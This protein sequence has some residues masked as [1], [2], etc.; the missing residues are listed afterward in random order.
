MRDDLWTWNH[1][2]LAQGNR[3]VIPVELPSFS[4]SHGSSR[5]SRC[6]PHQTEMSGHSMVARDWSR[7]RACYKGMWTLPS[8][9]EIVTSIQTSASA[10]WLTNETVGKGADRLAFLVK[11]KLLP[12][13]HVIFWLSRTYTPSGLRLPPHNQSQRQ[14]LFLFYVICSVD[15][16]CAKK[17]FLTMC[18]NLIR[19]NTRSFYAKLV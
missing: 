14:W 3:A 6:C 17:L 2:C 15:E 4:S 13:T 5:S 12:K 16:G 1:T 9:G 7:H 10:H 11:S 18:H 19:M 8:G